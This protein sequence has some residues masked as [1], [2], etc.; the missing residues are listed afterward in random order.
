MMSDRNPGTGPQIA[1]QRG[2]EQ[3][4]LNVEPE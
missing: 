4:C 2:A 1:V 3:N